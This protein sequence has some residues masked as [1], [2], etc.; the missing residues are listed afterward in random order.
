MSQF[1]REVVENSN[2]TETGKCHMFMCTKWCLL[3]LMVCHFLGKLG[4]S[5]NVHCVVVFSL[6]TWSP[7]N[8]SLLTSITISHLAIAKLVTG[9]TST[10]WISHSPLFFLYLPSIVTVTN[11]LTNRRPVLWGNWASTMCNVIAVL[12]G[13]LQ[14]STQANVAVGKRFCNRHQTLTVSLHISNQWTLCNAQKRLMT[15]QI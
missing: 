7:S 4:L 10:G 14:T 15:A 3:F 9:R 2:I 5:W 12:K 13:C 11:V 6:L 8:L 1:W